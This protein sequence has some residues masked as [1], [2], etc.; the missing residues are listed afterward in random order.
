V[1]AVLASL[2]SAAAQDLNIQHR[3]TYIEARLRQEPLAVLDMEQARP[4][5]EGDRSAKVQL[6]GYD[7]EPPI[8][9]KWKPVG[10]GGQGFNNEPRYEVAAYL[11]QK[12]FLEESEYVVPPTSLRSMRLVDYRALR[13]ASQPT[14]GGTQSVLFLLS[15]WVE[16]VTNRDPFQL[17]LFQS[18]TLYARYWSNVNVLTLLI[19][20]RDANL[21][22]L[23]I[24]V[25]PARP[26]VFAVDNDV[27]FA[28]RV[29]DQGDDWSRLHVDRLPLAT[30]TRLRALT[31]E[32]LDR[33]L[34]VVAEFEVVDEHL[35]AVEPG[36]NLNPGRGV[37]TTRERVQF[38]L[39]S[40]EIRDL[41]GR[42]ESL[43]A[44]VDRGRIRTF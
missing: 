8:Y 7:G 14:L 29:S 31:R 40:N 24:S 16:N 10:R 15:Y 22:N 28:S 37:R 38:G 6:A 26:R 35:V 43:L 33:A 9:T 32:D 39:T 3:V 42:I 25:D 44:D 12:L 21:G 41:H 18:D 19:R 1:L 20:H 23:L 34:G 30:V 36:A 17:R 27:A 5:I 13:A 2:Q 4:F 11:F